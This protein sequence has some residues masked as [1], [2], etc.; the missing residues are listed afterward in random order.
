MNV[1]VDYANNK[2]NKNCLNM[3]YVKVEIFN[4]NEIIFIL[5]SLLNHLRE[6]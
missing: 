1:V 3:Y 6:P 5:V 4:I 2:N